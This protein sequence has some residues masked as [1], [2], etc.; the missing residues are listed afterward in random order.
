MDHTGIELTLP[1]TS[2]PLSFPFNE[3]SNLPYMLPSKHPHF[4]KALFGA[5]F[6]NQGLLNNIVRDTPIVESFDPVTSIDEMNFLLAGDSTSNL[7]S[8]QKELRLLHNKVGHIGMKRLQQLL[9]H[10]RDLDSA[11]SDGELNHPVVFRSAFAKTRTC[12][13]PF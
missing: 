12:V 3:S 8:A 6:T 7:N 1:S 4:I 2:R 13:V 11:Q 9:H 5:N 10:E